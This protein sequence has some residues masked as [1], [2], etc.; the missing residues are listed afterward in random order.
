MIQ[1]EKTVS[2]SHPCL[3]TQGTNSCWIWSVDT[4]SQRRCLRKW[5]NPRRAT[6]RAK[7]IQKR[8]GEAYRWSAK[9]NRMQTVTRKYF[10]F[11]VHSNHQ[12]DDRVLEKGS[13]RLER[14]EARE[15][16]V[17]AK[18]RLA[19]RGFRT[20]V[21]WGNETVHAPADQMHGYWL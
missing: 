4:F 17:M 20:L 10:F 21:G 7:E 11:P 15:S 2:E 13:E 1:G 19:L 14:R 8:K 3:L 12:V 18:A 16:E 9:E 5:D 6:W